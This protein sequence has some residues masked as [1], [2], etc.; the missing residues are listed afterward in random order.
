MSPICYIGV[1]SDGMIDGYNKTCAGLIVV[2]FD[3]T[4]SAAMRGVIYGKTHSGRNNKVRCW[5]RLGQICQS[6][7]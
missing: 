1:L 4:E 3:C 5:L 2:T 6:Y 7:I